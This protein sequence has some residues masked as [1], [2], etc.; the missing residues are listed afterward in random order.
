M[1]ELTEKQKLGIEAIVFLQGL[2]G[3]DESEEDALKSWNSMTKTE[4][5]KTL[6]LYETERE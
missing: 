6:F 3:I 4:R 5:K 2:G 1:P